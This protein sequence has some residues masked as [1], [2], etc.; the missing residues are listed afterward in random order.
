MSA[1][2]LPYV[3]ALL[4]A[5]GVTPATAGPAG[6]GEA[7]PTLDDAIHIQSSVDRKSVFLGES[8]TLTLE[9]WELNFRG[10]KVQPYFRSGRVGVPDT[11]GFY[12]GQL[13]E[14]Q[15]EATRGGGLYTVTTYRQRLYPART[16]DLFIGAWSWKGTVRGHT[17]AGARAIDVDLATLPLE[18]QVRPL[19]NPPG[20]FKGAVG[21]YELALEFDDRELTRG[22]PVTMRLAVNGRGNPYT[23]QAPIIAEEPWFSLGDPVDDALEDDPAG[24]G[25]FTKR[26]RWTFMPVGDGQQTFPPVSLT[27]FSPAEGRY[28]VVR[29][30]PVPLE[31]E[32]GGPAEKLVV[33]GAGGAGPRMEIMDGGRLPLASLDG[34]FRIRR[35]RWNLWPPLIALPPLFFVALFLF[36][37]GPARI[38][39]W[40]NRGPARENVDARLT[41][42]SAHPRPFDALHSATRALLAERAGLEV[43]GMSVPEIRDL[44]ARQYDPGVSAAIADVLADCE[45]CRYGQKQADPGELVARA[46]VVFQGLPRKRG[47]WRIGR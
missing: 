46:R 9:Y 40:V 34:A 36:M 14:T 27:Y 4:C 38:R 12:A 43:A 28:K 47:R 30:T 31:I 11:E 25:R 18:V 6:E 41:A 33:I 24:G 39:A 29:T 45:S 2:S 35:A 13:E 37:Q 23:L 17:A 5:W 8:V 44:L 10:M 1:R 32:G 15:H 21:E 16:G 19:P 22:V 20:T 42:V 26:F 3:L 7:G